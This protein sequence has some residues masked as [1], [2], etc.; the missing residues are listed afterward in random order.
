MSETRPAGM[1]KDCRVEPAA[2]KP[3]G[4]LATR[5]KACAAKRSA[6][7]KAARETLRAKGLCTWEGG[8]A[9]RAAP[10]LTY[11]SEHAEYHAE[12]RR[13]ERKTAKTRASQMKKGRSR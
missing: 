9:Y 8:C 1:C 11:C 3:D 7:A 2:E 4:S 13:Q 5:C 12:R 10:G 6:A